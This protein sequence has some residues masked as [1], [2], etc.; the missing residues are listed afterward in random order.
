MFPYTIYFI[1][2]GVLGI[3][4]SEIIDLFA[5]PIIMKKI[6]KKLPYLFTMAEVEA[7][8]GGKIGMEIGSVREKI[9]IALL[10]YYFGRNSV[11]DKIPITK[12][13]TDVILFGNSMSI[14]TK[15]GKSLSGIKV[16]W[17]VDWD[18]IDEFVNSYV[19]KVDM[20]LARIVWGKHDGGLYYIPKTV[21]SRVFDELGRNEYLKTPRRGTNPRGVEYS[22]EAIRCMIGDIHSNSITIDWKRYDNKIDIYEKWE[23]YWAKDD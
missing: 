22:S 12:P 13:E 21:Q 7:S 23:V 17:T 14:K 15:T 11:S 5:N 8:R 20:I 9:I 1:K 4:M 6:R 2:C 16:I 10:R 3:Y 18:K 19:P